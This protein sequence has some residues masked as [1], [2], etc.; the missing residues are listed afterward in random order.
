MYFKFSSLFIDFK[1]KGRN[2]ATFFKFINLSGLHSHYIRLNT[3]PN[4]T[5]L[6][7][8]LQT[9]LQNQTKQEGNEKVTSLRSG[10]KL[11]LMKKLSTYLFLVLFSFS[12]PS[13]ADD[14]SDFQIEGMSIGDSLL[15]YLTEE[16]I[17][18]KEKYIEIVFSSKSV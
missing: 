9:S 7:T 3:T 18:N 2:F 1:K 16:E 4:N 10:V 5:F 8:S 14:I 11:T 17:K 12:A 15:D 13:F 6:K